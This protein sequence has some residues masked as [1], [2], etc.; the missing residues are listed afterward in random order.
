[1]C[2]TGFLKLMMF[3]FNGTIFLAGAAILGVGIWVKVDSN[4]FMGI[5]DSVEELPSE[6]SQVANIAYLLIAVGAIL[7][8]IGF[9]GCCGAMRESRCMLL[10][11]F[12]IVLIIFIIEVAGAVVLLVFKDVAEDL[13]DNLETEVRKG[14]RAKFG[15]DESLTS[16]WTT[17]ME[18]FQCCGY[19][20][21]TDFYSSPFYIQNNGSY[22]SQCCNGTDVGGM[23]SEAAA[24]TAAH[25]QLVDGCFKK[26]LQ[27]IEE[28]A[29]IVAVVALGIAALEIAAMVVSMV[30]YKDIGNKA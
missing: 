9:L 10:L 11:F 2:C 25:L 30:L 17:T 7:L 4:S 19:T 20:N 29:L 21:Y 26:L 23:C 22:P 14:L 5:L 6:I 3:I 1:M 8:V 18:G 27:L 24:E 16:L 13:F 12:S 28:N 15:S